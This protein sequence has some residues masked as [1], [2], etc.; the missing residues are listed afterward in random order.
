M[1]KIKAEL[2]W[3]SEHHCGSLYIADANF[4]I[5]PDRDNEI[6]DAIIENVT[7]HGY[8]KV[9]NMTWAKNKKDDVVALARRWIDAGVLSPGFTM[10]VQSLDDVVLDNIKRQ[11]MDMNKIES[12]F[13]LCERVGV[14]V[15]T[16]LILG[17]PGETPASWRNNFCTYY[18]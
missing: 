8:P 1:E 5:F 10:S 16:E 15:N 4:G 13:E 14:P 17:L 18:C 9:F 3:F 12:M 2:R 6:V 11:N 7:Q